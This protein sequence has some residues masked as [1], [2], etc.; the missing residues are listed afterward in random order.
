MKSI[1]FIGCGT[2]VHANYAKTLPAIGGWQVAYCADLNTAQAES[3]AAIFGA[4]VVG[5]DEVIAKSDAII[6]TTPPSTHAAL[7]ERSLGSNRIVICEKPFVTS[8]QDAKRLAELSAAQGA[9]LF[10][11]HFRRTFPQVRLARSLVR[12]GMI[13]RIVSIKAFEGGRFTW[14][15]VSNYVNQDRAGGVLWDTGSHTLDMALYAGDL[16]SCGEVALADIDVQRDR[17]EP[18]HDIKARFTLKSD[19]GDIRFHVHNSR[20]EVLPNYIEIV[21]ERGTIRFLLGLEPT[22][23]LSNEHGSVI[24]A[25]DEKAQEDYMEYFGL[26]LERILNDKEADEFAANRFITLTSIIETVSNAA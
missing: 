2:V 10:V 4:K 12:Q 13:G 3:A 15:A 6:V 22:L 16:D 1:G 11:G 5:A 20:R 26:Q 18:S 9:K 24:L 17:P 14:Q 23:R 21:G 7:V 8:T 25:S 19:R